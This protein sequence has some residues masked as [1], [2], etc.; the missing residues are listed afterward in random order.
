M[1]VDDEAD[2]GPDPATPQLE[3]DRQ[4]AEACALCGGEKQLPV[5]EFENGKPVLKGYVTCSPCGGTG[6]RKR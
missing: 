3:D 6:R 2:F 1:G 4:Q 5:V